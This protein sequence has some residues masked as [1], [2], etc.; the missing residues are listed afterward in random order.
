MISS[1]SE[2]PL[3][4][5]S[6]S[7]RGLPDVFVQSGVLYTIPEE[8]GAHFAYIVTNVEVCDGVLQ[9]IDTVFCCAHGQIAKDASFWE[10]E[11]AVFSPGAVFQF[12]SADGVAPIA[13]RDVDDE[14]IVYSLNADDIAHMDTDLVRTASN[15]KVFPC[16]NDLFVSK[17]HVHGE[18]GKSY[19]E[20]HGEQCSF[21]IGIFGESAKHHGEHEER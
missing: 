11:V 7:G 10:E 15:V 17:G 8:W 20:Q 14:E 1:H 18:G 5:F 12:E 9:S 2:Q 3:L 13:H 6:T 4:S 21:F 16:L 19:E